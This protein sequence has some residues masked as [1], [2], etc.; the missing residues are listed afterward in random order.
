MKLN[1]PG[2]QAWSQIDRRITL[3]NFGLKSISLIIILSIQ[4][5]FVLAEESLKYEISQQNVN[6]AWLSD[7]CAEY[8]SVI[9]ELNDKAK[10]D[11]HK[12]TQEN[13]GK[14]LEI[15]FSGKVITQAVIKTG[16]D[17]G[18]IQVGKWDHKK[19]AIKFIETLLQN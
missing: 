8:Y 13:I 9:I 4:P 1:L 19:D 7:S 5:F 10:I 12:L 6:A 3:K 17:T 15:S 2:F 14:K 16:I 11:F 18:V